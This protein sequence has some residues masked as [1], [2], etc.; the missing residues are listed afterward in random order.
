M[1]LSKISLNTRISLILK[2]SQVNFDILRR[3]NVDHEIRDGCVIMFLK[4]LVDTCSSETLVGDNFIGKAII[5]QGVQASV[6]SIL[7]DNWSYKAWVI[8]G[9]LK[10][11]SVDLMIVPELTKPN[12]NVLLMRMLSN[13]LGIPGTNNKS[14]ILTMISLKNSCR[15][16]LARWTVR[17]K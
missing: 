3:L 2:C 12:N 13:I 6:S 1:R 10:T 15:L 7:D 16:S 5:D 17:L 14:I 9:F 11:G 4:A 8:K